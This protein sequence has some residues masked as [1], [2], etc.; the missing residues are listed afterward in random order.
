MSSSSSFGTLSEFLLQAGTEYFVIDL[1][2]TRNV[3]DNQ[4]FFDYET[5]KLPYATPRQGN[6]WLCVV[7]WN[8]QMNQE[9]YM[10]FLK[11]PIDEQSLLQQ[12][13]RDQFL[14]IVTEALG[15][16]LQNVDQKQAQL[17]DNP[18]VFIPSQQLLADCNALIRHR[19]GLP[20]RASVKQ[21]LNYIKAP[22]VQPWSTLS[23]QDMSDLAIMIDQDEVQQAFVQN[24]EILPQPVCVCLC[25]A[26]E[27]IKLPQLVQER[28]LNFH[29]HCDSSLAPMILRALAS[30]RSDTV[31]KYIQKL[32]ASENML[33]TETL[34]VIAGRH[35]QALSPERAFE[36]P[37]STVEKGS[38]DSNLLALYFD[39]VAKAD[40][41]FALFR[42]IF[43]D[44]VQL[45]SLRV[46]LLALL[47]SEHD[48]DALKK[49]SATLFTQEKTRNGHV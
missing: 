11:L 33:D 14:H 3:I 10:W 1:S 9:H 40:G 30:S 7:F 20:Q 28:L 32:I 44:M 24:L 27:G 15:Q 36:Q 5:N 39:K 37:S 42:G 22:N 47:R 38:T 25:S 12:A 23:V 13:A 34:V 31:D 8:K 46:F 45:P 26:F 41:N 4:L 29:P 49:A 35:W 48:Y 17:P 2:R 18:F 43:T 16:Q 6:A 19:L 21:A